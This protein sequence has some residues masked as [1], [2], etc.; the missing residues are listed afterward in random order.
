M[1]RI[2]LVIPIRSARQLTGRLVG[3]I[4]VVP[5]TNALL[6]LQVRDLLLGL[7]LT[8]FRHGLLPLSATSVEGML[9]TL[10][11]I[12]IWL[13]S[14][15]TRSMA[16]VINWEQCLPRTC[17]TVT[18]RV[19]LSEVLTFSVVSILTRMLLLTLRQLRSTFIQSALILINPVS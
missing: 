17:W 10:A 12:S 14:L 15:V 8:V 11:P 16:G 13:L 6:K 4:I 1:L 3:T 19:P 18:S 7:I 2:W 5:E 9:R